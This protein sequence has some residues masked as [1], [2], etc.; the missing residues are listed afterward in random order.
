VKSIREKEIQ[1]EAKR[2]KQNM[3]IMDETPKK[4]TKTVDQNKI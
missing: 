3:C 4:K 1:T 2:G